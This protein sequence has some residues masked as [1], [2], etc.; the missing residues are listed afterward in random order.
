MAMCRRLDPCHFGEVYIPG[1]L[2]LEL[3]FKIKLFDFVPVDHNNAGFFR[4]CG[5]D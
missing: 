3:A 2:S 1:K 5:I 4:V